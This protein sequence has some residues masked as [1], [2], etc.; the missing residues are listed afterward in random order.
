M[1][2]GGGM[3]GWLVVLLMKKVLG[4]VVD[5]ILVEFEVIG[6]VGVGEVIIFLICLVN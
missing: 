3:V 5:I 2:V 1:I 4:K 6:M